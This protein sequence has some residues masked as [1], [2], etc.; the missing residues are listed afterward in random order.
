M[1]PQLP[2]ESEFQRR[3][4][5]DERLDDA[6]T[7]VAHIEGELR[8]YATKAELSETETR[9]GRMEPRLMRW[10]IGLMVGSAA[11]AASVVFIVIR[12]ID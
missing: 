2:D 3:R 11:V 8:H 9:L 4:Y 7:R 10:M 5:Y 1:R 6:H 12:L